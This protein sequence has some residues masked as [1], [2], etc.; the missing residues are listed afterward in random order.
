MGDRGERVLENRK[1]AFGV[2]DLDPDSMFDAWQVHSA[3]CVK[4]EGPRGDR[5]HQ[6]ADI[7]VTDHMEV[8]LFMRFADCVPIMLYDPRRKAIGLAHAG[9]QGTVRNAAGA[10]VKAMK[11]AFGSDASDLRAGLGPSIGPDHYPVGEEVLQKFRV[12]FG[13]GAG[14]HF[15]M[16]G[17]RQYL[18]LWTANQ[19]LLERQ[20]V[21]Q[22]EVAGI[23]TACEVEHWYSHRAEKGSTGRFGAVLSLRT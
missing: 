11:D 16:R 2:L 17:G 3:E 20:G 22:V 1:R 21:G 23:C 18:N 4:V 9:W 13:E 10:A 8:S 6:K 14:E 7:L 15:W 19:V 12:S 5:P